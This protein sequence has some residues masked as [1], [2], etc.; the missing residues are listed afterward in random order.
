[1]RVYVYLHYAL[2]LFLVIIIIQACAADPNARQANK[3]QAITALQDSDKQ[4]LKQSEAPPPPPEPPKPKFPILTPN[5]VY[6]LGQQLSKS[7]GQIQQEL[8]RRP[9]RLVK[10]PY[11]TSEEYAAR[12]KQYQD[13]LPI[14]RDSVESA[15]YA[16]FPHG[17]FE[18]RVGTTTDNYDSDTEIV[19][20]RGPSNPFLSF[21]SHFR[22]REHGFSIS[23]YDSRFPGSGGFRLNAPLARETAREIDVLSINSTLYVWFKVLPR[24]NFPPDPTPGQNEIVIRRPP[25][26]PIMSIDSIAWEVEGDILWSLAEGNDH[27]DHPRR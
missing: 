24:V 4:I 18:M 2:G 27:F 22:F 5:E 13:R 7:W 25:W 17:P 16:K 10:D 1:M 19:R 3:E 14:Q 23:H 8:N 9:N 20:L 21:P 12:N 15:Y 11:E 6:A 26:T